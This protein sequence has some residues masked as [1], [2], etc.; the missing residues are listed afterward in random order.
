M[1]YMSTEQAADIRN[2][3]KEAFP[4]KD[5]W[6]LSVRKEHHTGIAVT[7]M[8]GIQGPEQ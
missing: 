1:A 3:L 5:G 4:A 6:K 2:R 7:F 8:E